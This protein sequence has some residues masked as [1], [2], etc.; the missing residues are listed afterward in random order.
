[1]REVSAM[2]WLGAE[3]DDTYE[4]KTPESDNSPKYKT[5]SESEKNN[6]F[7]WLGKEG[8]QG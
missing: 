8:D 5:C 7:F 3:G 2:F 6:Y 1:M 4:R